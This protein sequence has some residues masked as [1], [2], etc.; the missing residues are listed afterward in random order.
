MQCTLKSVVAGAVDVVV[1]MES[2]VRVAC[3]LLSQVL[4]LAP[5]SLVLSGGK[6]RAL[7]KKA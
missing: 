7:E 3:V 6:K 1:A 5:L 2:A 4:L